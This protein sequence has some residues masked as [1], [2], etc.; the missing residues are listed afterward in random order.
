MDCSCFLDDYMSWD[1]KE[2][3]KDW[4]CKV[5]FSGFDTDC[6]CLDGNLDCNWMGN[7]DCN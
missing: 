7:S 4:G 5:V 1:N 6:C 3:G 2:T